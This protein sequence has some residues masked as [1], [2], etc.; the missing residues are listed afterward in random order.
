[1]AE[2]KPQP[3]VAIN[4]ASVQELTGI[5]GIG[6]KLAKAIVAVRRSSG[7]ITPEILTSIARRQFT[8]DELQL[9]DFTPNVENPEGQ[10]SGSSSD[11]EEQGAGHDQANATWA[12]YLN[13]AFTSA[14]KWLTNFSFGVKQG[15][16]PRPKAKPRLRVSR[17]RRGKAALDTM[18]DL[19]PPV[20]KASATGSQVSDTDSGDDSVDTQTG[21]CLSPAPV[22]QTPK[23]VLTSTPVSAFTQQLPAKV[24]VASPERTA[25]IPKIPLV[26]R[27]DF[28]YSVAPSSGNRKLQAKELLATLPKNL[29]YDGKGNWKAFKLQFTRYASTCGWTEEDSLNC[30]CWSLKGKALDYYAVISDGSEQLTYKDL[31]QRLEHRFG[32]QEV[33]ATAQARFQQANQN[34]GESLEDWADRVLTLS[35]R[36]YKGLPETF[37][38]E[39]AV[40]KFC[41]GMADKDAGH[42]VCMQNPANVQSAIQLVLKYQQV[43][44]AMYG[45]PRG[46]GRKQ[47][48]DDSYHAVNQIKSEPSD[49]STPADFRQ[50]LQDLEK[51]LQRS[52]LE[53]V[54]DSGRRPRPRS[55]PSS[56]ACYEC[57]EIGHFRRDCPKLD[58]SRG[59]SKAYGAGRSAGPRPKYQ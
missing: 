43:H 15:I 23:P 27:T 33:P 10:S 38:T 21:D 35:G 4:F 54:Q 12:G 26:N 22:M 58:T 30:L 9:V 59:Q 47:A 40:N 16:Q 8:E 32:E 37:T 13:D 55:R 39:Q 45:K 41:Q 31:L 29:T 1:M 34:P 44:S 24:R 6:H 49:A 25:T 5:P 20:P 17:Q 51:R 3:T 7:N 57:G 28:Q 42:H 46:S 19:L 18:L 36:A 14:K 56:K 50:A 52:I 48:W 11:E 2:I 53:T